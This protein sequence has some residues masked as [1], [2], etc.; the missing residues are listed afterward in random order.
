MRKQRRRLTAIATIPAAVLGL[1]IATPP[2][3][4]GRQAP[5]SSAAD[6]VRLTCSASMTNS[7]P[8]DYTSTGVRVRTAARARI[9]TAAHYRTTTH[10]KYRTADSHGRRT[11]WYYISSATPGYKVVVDVYVAKAGKKGSCST[12]FIPHR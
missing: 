8:A 11:V 6:P 4:A 5:A 2:A 3:W 7:H 12:S 10:W 1:T 9:S